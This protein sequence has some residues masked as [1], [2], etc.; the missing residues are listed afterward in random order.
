MIVDTSA[1]MAAL[2][3]ETEAALFISMIEAAEDVRIS[4]G[5]CVE[6]AI[7]ATRRDQP[8]AIE[9]IDQFLAMGGITIEPVTAE[10]ALIARQAH[11][12]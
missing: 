8:I 11:F 12:A 2:L 1:I 3:G 4:A 9:K 7:T 6:L 10:Q 5:N